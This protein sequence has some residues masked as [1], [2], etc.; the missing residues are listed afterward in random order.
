MAFLNEGNIEVSLVFRF[1]E[2]GEVE[3]VYSSERFEK[4]GKTYRK[5]AWEG[6]FSNFVQKAGMRVPLH[7]EVGWYRHDSLELVWKGEIAHLHYEFSVDGRS[8]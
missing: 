5:A 3:G 1:N 4:V 7:G 8:T 2:A 6:R